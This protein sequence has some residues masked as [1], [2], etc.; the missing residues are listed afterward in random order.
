MPKRTQ[1]EEAEQPRGA[2]IRE[3]IREYATPKESDEELDD[4]L[5]DL[6]DGDDGNDEPSPR[7][8]KR[9]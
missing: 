1:S 7:P 9:K 2:V 6:D 5:D 3:T 8:R 4:D